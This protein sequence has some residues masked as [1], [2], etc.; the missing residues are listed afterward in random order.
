[1]VGMEQGIAIWHACGL[2]A[3]SNQLSQ[4]QAGALRMAAA[5]RPIWPPTVDA[6][7]PAYDDWVLNNVQDSMVGQP[8]SKTAQDQVVPSVLRP[9]VAANYR[10]RAATHG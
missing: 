10:E 4:T 8:L 9:I 7:S 2:A 5:A 3:P 6:R 1:M